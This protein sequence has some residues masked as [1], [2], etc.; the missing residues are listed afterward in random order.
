M[1]QL[2]A[3]LTLSLSLVPTL[4]LANPI[5]FQDIPEIK[6]L[7]SQA[8]TFCKITPTQGRLPKSEELGSEHTTW[9]SDGMG[10]AIPETKNRITDKIV[11]ARMPEPIVGETY[12]EWLIPKSVWQETYGKLPE[13]HEFTDSY[14]SA[15]IEAIKVTHEVL[16]L[17]ESNDQQTALIAVSWDP[18]G[19][20]VY[21]DGLLAENE[22]GIAPEEMK[23][24]YRKVSL[25]PDQNCLDILI[26]EKP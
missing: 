9:V 8:E 26:Q 23:E 14:R 3:P 18:A 21:K 6:A 12:N 15:P 5:V 11:I 22:Y 2:L 25:E 19:M 20:K 7:S 17:L 13:S 16:E 1:K 24:N 10:G 4:S